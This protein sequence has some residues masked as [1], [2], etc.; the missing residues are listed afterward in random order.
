[1]DFTVVPMLGQHSNQSEGG[2]RFQFKH[3]G[4]IWVASTGAVLSASFSVSICI[5]MVH[6]PVIHSFSFFGEVVQQLAL[7]S[8]SYYSAFSLTYLPLDLLIHEDISPSP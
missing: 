5:L 4:E 2:T 7:S 1:M 3:L 8:S 6:H